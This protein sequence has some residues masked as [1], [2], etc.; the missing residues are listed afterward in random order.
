MTGG[1]PI[2]GNPHIVTIVVLWS[3]R[4]P[5][6]KL[7]ACLLGIR[8][9]AHVPWVTLR[10]SMAN[11]VIIK[12]ACMLYYILFIYIYIDIITYN[13]Y[14][15]L[16]IYNIICA[17]MYIYIHPPCHFLHR[18]AGVD[19]PISLHS[20]EKWGRG[21]RFCSKQWVW[22]GFCNFLLETS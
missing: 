20:V 16:Y 6:W 5:C 14:I 10:W 13:V 8:I 7:F 3:R 22:D 18:M 17:Y 9:A 11:Q 21:M 12:L 1:T 15:T 4:V 19:P 2:P